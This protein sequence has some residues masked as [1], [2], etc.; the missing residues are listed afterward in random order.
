MKYL[1]L[2]FLVVSL[3]AAALDLP[4]DEEMIKQGRASFKDVNPVM[5]QAQRDV[6][7][8]VKH[9]PTP[10]PGYDR[11]LTKEMVQEMMHPDWKKAAAESRGGSSDLIVFVSFSMPDDLLIQ[12]S[13]QAKEAGAT[14]VLRGLYQD[15]LTKTQLKAAPLN[16]EMVGYEINP[17]LFRKFKVTRVPS[18]VLVDSRVTKVLEDGCALPGVYIKVD[19]DVSIREALSLMRWQGEKNMSA[20]AAKRLKVIEGS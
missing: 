3:Q 8:G 17:G 12:Y 2:F 9:L 15:S 1:S 10:S 7:A 11:G 20:I 19:G 13:K 14:L 6:D 16:P 5:D 4:S 18:I